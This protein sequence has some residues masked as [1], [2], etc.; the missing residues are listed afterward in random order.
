MVKRLKS[1]KYHLLWHKWCR[2]D[3]TQLIWNVHAQL[4]SIRRRSIVV[5]LILS[6]TNIYG[7]SNEDFIIPLIEGSPN[8]A[9][10]NIRLV[11]FKII[12]QPQPRNTRH[13]WWNTGGDFVTRDTLAIFLANSLTVFLFEFWPQT[14]TLEMFEKNTCKTRDNDLE[15][16][17]L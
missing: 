16:N 4:E 13:Q 3:A 10:Q 9:V 12:P 1:S 6:L 15:C 8:Y 11:K 2:L 17:A 14:F 5:N 7:F